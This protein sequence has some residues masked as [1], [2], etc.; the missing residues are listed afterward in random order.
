MKS[1]I[2]IFLKLFE[3]FRKKE[4]Y[5]S[6]DYLFIYL[7][8]YLLIIVISQNDIKLREYRE[9]KGNSILCIILNT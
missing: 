5:S 1:L 3:L 4:D 6:F 9:E 7:F 8:I 2:S